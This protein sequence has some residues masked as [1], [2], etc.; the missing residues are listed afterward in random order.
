M[1]AKLT[2]AQIKEHLKDTPIE[3]ILG[4]AVSRELTPRQKKFALEVAQGNTKADA[5]RKAYNARSKHTMTNKPYVLARDERVKAE[6]KA[7]EAAIEAA[8]HRTPAALRELVISS[9]VSV[10]IDD[11]AKQTAKVA[12]AKVLGTVTEVAAFTERKEVTTITSSEAVKQKIMQELRALMNAQ[13]VD[14]VEVDATDLLDELAPADPHP[15][16]TPPTHEAESPSCTHTIPLKGTPPL[17]VP[18]S[19]PPPP[20]FCTNNEQEGR[21]PN[22]DTPLSGS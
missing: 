2:K 21:N 10:L 11:E 15:A 7:Y 17:S 12:A 4:K 13:A 18:E 22:G 16:P 8:K 9:L 6:I 20:T 3:A 1:V 14:A 19:D 5:Y